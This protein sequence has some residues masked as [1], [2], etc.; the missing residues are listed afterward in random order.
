[1]HPISVILIS[2]NASST[3]RACLKSLSDF[4]EVL[5]LLDASTTDDTG[6]IAGEF[7]NVRVAHSP[8][9]G[10]GKMK[11]LAQQLAKYDWVFS[12]DSDEVVPS[13]LSKEI[14][15][16]VLSDPTQVYYIHRKN[17]YQK[18]HIDACGWNNDVILRL[19]NR[20]FT[21]FTD[22]RIHESV[23][24]PE[25]AK[26]NQL[27][28]SLLHYPYSNVKG[29]LEKL[30]HYSELYAEENFR[31]KK[32]STGKAL[33]KGAFTFFKDYILRKGIFYG[34]EGFLIS[35][36]NA[37]GAFYK[38]YKLK[39]RNEKLRISLIVSTYNR[40]DALELVLKSVFNQRILPY[41]IILADDGS[42][43]ETRTLIEK[44]QQQSPV[45]M[46]HVWHE[47]TGFRLAEIRN[48]AIAAAEGEFISMIDG[49][50]LLH[51]D[52]LLILVSLVQKNTYYQ[53]K[54]VLLTKE[55]TEQLLESGQQPRLNF[56]SSGFKNRFNTISSSFLS[57]LL[58]KKKNTINAVK[59]CSMHFWKEDAIRI[60][61]FN[62]NF[63]GWGRE[64][65]EF[66]CR[67]L[68]KGI[69]RKNIVFGS[70][71]YHLF[72]PEASRT[73]LPENDQ[74]LAHAIEAKTTWCENGLNQHLFQ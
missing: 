2:K 58:T 5:L 65:S 23:F 47:D 6:I 33:W 74:I 52:F 54:R 15:T 22:R 30:N 19:Y 56:F 64:D 34:S 9:L 25:G 13:E 27:K 55:K 24:L 14:Q 63:V 68:N 16:L 10:F 57:P 38:Y 44:F 69:K 3:I 71:A 20:T 35:L 28:N 48:K 40:P 37:N 46:K 31:K 21:G 53:G 70:V 26:K 32:S 39:E 12:I 18:K 51:P 59:G 50:M 66:V 17:H 36:C 72:H 7:P 41:E 60:N 8:F 29:L 67:L 43:T 45:P 42:K 49:D 1:V 11:A 73:M 61:G 4:Q 62:Q